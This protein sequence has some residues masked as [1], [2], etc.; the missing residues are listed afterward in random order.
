VELVFDGPKHI[1][2]LKQASLTVQSRATLSH[3]R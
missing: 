1:A 2:D 3:R